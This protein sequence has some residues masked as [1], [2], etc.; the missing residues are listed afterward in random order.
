MS[1]LKYIDKFLSL[2]CAADV[3]G[4]SYPIKQFTK[5]ISEAMAMITHI[6]SKML[7]SPMKYVLIDLCSGNALVPLISAFML[8]SKWNYA[9]DIRERNRSW[10]KAERFNYKNKNIFEEEVLDFIN[11]TASDAPVILSACHSCKNLA[12]RCIELY[13]NSN[14]L[15]YLVWL[16]I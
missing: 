7:K 11:K 9:I 16:R 12:E 1:Q 3:I 15:T 4:I 6:K 8:P 14:I 10:N 13:N 2:R 5:E